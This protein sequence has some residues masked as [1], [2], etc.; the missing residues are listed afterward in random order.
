MQTATLFHLLDA[1]SHLDHGID[2]AQRLVLVLG[3]VDDDHPAM[4]VD[5]GRGQ[6]DAGC[7][8]HGLEHVVDQLA[9]GFVDLVD[10]GRTGPQARIRE[11]EYI[12]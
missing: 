4:N 8:V 6:A 3:E 12:Q 1:V 5:L 11:V 9:H 2:Q 10:R 7:R